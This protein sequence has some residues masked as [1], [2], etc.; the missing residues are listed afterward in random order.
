M[1]KFQIIQTDQAPAAVGP[2]SQ[3]IY[4]AQPGVPLFI[5]GQL[6]VNPANGQMV[7]EDTAE[8]AEQALTN[9]Q[10][11]LK[12]TGLSLQDIVQVQVFLCDMADYG[13]VNQIYSQKF[14]EHKPARAAFAVQG[15]PLGARVEILAIAWKPNP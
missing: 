6:G 3:A 15:L 13:A 7:S 5:S 11:I 8:Q 12:E 1:A 14:G 2:Y 10:A 4:P 9:I